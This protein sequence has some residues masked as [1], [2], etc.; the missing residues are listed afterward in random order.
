MSDN[1]EKPAR[2]TTEGRAF[3]RVVLKLSGEVL[4]GEDKHGINVKVIRA[5]AEEIR[6]IHRDGVE[7]ALV[8]GGGNI[9][10]GVKA[11]SD[12]MD[13][14]IGDYMGMMATVINGLALQ[15]FLEKEGLTTRLQTAIE[16]K[17]VAEPFIRRKAIRHLEKKRIV[18]LSG[19]TGNPYF[20]TD[21]TAA[22]R[23]VELDADVIFKAT[24]VDGVYD[25]D[26]VKNPAAKRYRRLS[27]HDALVKQLKVMDSTAFSLCL[28]NKMPIQVFDMS[29][30]GNLKKAV[31]GK[32]IGTL[33]DANGESEFYE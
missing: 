18:I 22:L 1:S 16:I 32:P 9:F 8:I 10:R 23:A 27:F 5:L 33:I 7:L 29:K 19:G 28:D 14:A 11:A 25:S 13:R 4:A 12:G 21:T 26:P 2:G 15:D 31:Q 20:T 24:K 3:R 30:E 6:D 17:S